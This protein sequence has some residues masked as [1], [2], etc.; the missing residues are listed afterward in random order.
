MTNWMKVAA[1]LAAAGCAV[2][3]AGAAE[4]AKRANSGDAYCTLGTSNLYRK[5]DGSFY[6]M[7][8]SEFAGDAAKAVYPD[9]TKVLDPH[10]TLRPYITVGYKLELSPQGAPAGLTAIS[11][12]AAAGKLAAG[13]PREG[14][15]LKLEV[16]GGGSVAIPVETSSFIISVLMGRLNSPEYAM[17]GPSVPAAALTRLSQAVQRGPRTIVVTSNGKDVARIPIADADKAAQAAKMD[18]AR[19]ATALLKDDNCP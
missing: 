6:A 3:P 9:G 7:F 11:L 13:Y 18:T 17:D 15:G 16:P 1:W 14:L 4:K 5:A 2:A 8:S 12:N 10:P 19:K